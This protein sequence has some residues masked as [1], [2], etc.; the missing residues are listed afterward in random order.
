[1]SSYL[2][3][4]NQNAFTHL[5]AKIV[6]WLRGHPP[7]VEAEWPSGPDAYLWGPTEWC[8]RCGKIFRGYVPRE[9]IYK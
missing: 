5:M 8:S 1:M 9:F 4:R 3:R 7:Q 6:C 2:R